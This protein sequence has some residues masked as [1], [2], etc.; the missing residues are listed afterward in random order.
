MLL[1]AVYGMREER[2]P[3]TLEFLS[4]QLEEQVDLNWNWEDVTKVTEQIKSSAGPR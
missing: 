1:E 3:M 2:S 4:K